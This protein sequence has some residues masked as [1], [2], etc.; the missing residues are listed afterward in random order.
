VEDSLDESMP[1]SSLVRDWWADR[2][3][4]R[5]AVCGV[6]CGVWGRTGSTFIQPP[7]K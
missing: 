7:T 4:G 6:G 2:A 3:C 1:W 5:K